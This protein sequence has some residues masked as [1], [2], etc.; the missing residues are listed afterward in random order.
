MAF[1]AKD[2]VYA[3][4]LGHVGTVVKRR[5]PTEDLYLVRFEFE[6]YIDA[7]NL[8]LESEMIAEIE[9]SM[10]KPSWSPENVEEI[11][12]LTQLLQKDLPRG[13]LSDETIESL[14]KLNLIVSLNS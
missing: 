6:V 10:P 1:Q 11:N 3:K 12:R 14:K 7:A 5:L 4:K 9:E 2:K 8:Q 13:D